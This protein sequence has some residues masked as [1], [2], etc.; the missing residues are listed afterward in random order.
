MQATIALK[1]LLATCVLAVAVVMFTALS[2][3]AWGYAALLW[4][5]SLAG[6]PAGV[7]AG[8][9]LSPMAFR[10][11]AAGAGA[12]T[13]AHPEWGSI[14]RMLGGITSTQLVEASGAAFTAAATLTVA[15]A[16]IARR[17]ER[18]EIHRAWACLQPHH[19][20]VL[21]EISRQGT[22]VQAA[23]ILGIPRDTVKSRAYHAVKAFGLAL[24]EAGESRR[25]RP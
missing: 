13:I 18:R 25:H 15:A 5:G 12:A 7:W 3:P 19:R 6:G 17:A 11:I 8:R 16:L 14:A 24:D 1:N 2:A 22:C 21:T 20:Q 23:V 10:L 9:R 4:A